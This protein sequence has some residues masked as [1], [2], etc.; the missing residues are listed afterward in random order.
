MRSSAP[1]Q[2]V[3]WGRVSPP[4]AT[5]AGKPRKTHPRMSPNSLHPQEGKAKHYNAIN[6]IRVRPG[7]PLA[8]GPLASYQRKDL[9]R[10]ADELVAL[11]RRVKDDAPVYLK[12]EWAFTESNHEV[13]GNI[14]KCHLKKYWLV[15]TA[16]THKSVRHSLRHFLSFHRS[17]SEPVGER[18]MS[19]VLI[20]FDRL[21]TA[22]LGKYDA[23]VKKCTIENPTSKAKNPPKSHLYSYV[24]A[25]RQF[26][27]ITGGFLH[28]PVGYRHSTYRSERLGKSLPMP[29]KTG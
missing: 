9:E 17:R 12:I 1:R 25:L 16:A 15:G 23:S 27:R 20:F 3:V 11:W 26:V 19:S 4:T 13:G 5:N 6:D 18:D 21:R 22:L 14:L 2:Y 8:K 10:A 24:S 28:I 29:A 7:K